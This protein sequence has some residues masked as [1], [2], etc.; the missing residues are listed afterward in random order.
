[1]KSKSAG[2]GVAVLAALFGVPGLTTGPALAATGLAD[3]PIFV[4]SVPG[5]LLLDLSVEFPTAISVANIGSY[6]DASTYL[7]Y[8]DPVK[9]YTYQFNTTTP[10]QSYFQAT[11]FSTGTYS[12]RCSG[13]W[14]GNFMNW[15]SMQTIDPFR[16]ALSGGYRNVDTP[17]M[18]ILE[19]A[20][21]SSQG[22]AG[23]NFNYR[24][25]LMPSPNTLPSSLIGA[26]TPFSSWLAFDS[27]IWAFGNRMVFTP[28][29]SRIQCPLRTA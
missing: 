26:V 9:C 2:I 5:N 20:W 22:S 8:F 21:G 10:N 6:A 7:G 3:Q 14:S 27:A 23:Y 17:S 12:H 25:S 18:T 15:A 19:K 11:A 28:C 1:M 29:P 4:A 13:Q 16:S 24:G